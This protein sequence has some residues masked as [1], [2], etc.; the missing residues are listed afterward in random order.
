MKSNEKTCYYCDPEGQYCPNTC[1]NSDFCYW[2][3]ASIDKTQEDIKLKLENYAKSGGFLRGIILKKA[4]LIGVDLVH[5]HSKEG[6]DFSYADFYRANL[7]SAHLFNCTLNNA[8]LMKADLRDA[9][10]HRAKLHNANLLGVRWQGSK[11]EK[12]QLGDKL[13]QQQ[14]AK[15]A[16]KNN[17]IVAATDYLEQAEEIYRDLRKHSEQEGMFT[18][19]GELIQ[20]ELTMRRLQLPKY[21]SQRFFSK[22]IDIFCGYGEA[23]LRIISFS[24][25]LIVCCAFIYMFTGLNFEGNIQYLEW[26]YSFEKNS[27]IFFSSLYYSVVTFTTLGYGDFTPVGISRAVAAFE[28]FTG[29]FTIALFVVV[30]VKKM[31]R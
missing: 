31:T 27:D 11:I 28:A 1:I 25:I 3:N 19:S 16:Y 10:L 2:H 20:K 15:Q 18:L 21:S 6:Y 29:S 4:P 12:I 7:H 13:L 17:N 14:K 23:P 24:L 8:S 22:L 26:D 9:N 30:F 5:H